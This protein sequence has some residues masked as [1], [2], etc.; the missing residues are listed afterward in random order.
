MN[1]PGKFLFLLVAMLSMVN[2]VYAQRPG[3]AGKVIDKATSRPVIDASVSLGPIRTKTDFKGDFVF[4]TTLHR[5]DTLSV[6]SLTHDSLEFIIHPSKTLTSLRIELQP[7][8]VV[9]E[10]VKIV[11]SPGYE[12]DSLLTRKQFERI[13]GYDAPRVIEAFSLTSI[14]VAMLYEAL[15][16]EKRLKVNLQKRLLEDEKYKMAQHRYSKQMV[17]QLTK[18]EGEALDDF[19][20]DHQPSVDFILEANDYD[21][22]QYIKKRYEE[23]KNKK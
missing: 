19:Y 9:L 16:K 8:S 11:V 4:W 2:C 17:E 23:Y 18:L 5:Q 7:K 13:F 12:A 20:F 21:L 10:D 6:S 1:G 22:I 15:S 3:I 14:N